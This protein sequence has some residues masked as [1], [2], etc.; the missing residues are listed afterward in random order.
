MHKRI[1]TGLLLSSFFLIVLLFSNPF[2]VA[3]II[4][5]TSFIAYYEWLAVAQKKN[6]EKILFLSILL[7]SMIIMGYFSNHDL[8]IF[9]NFIYLAFWLIISIDICFGSYLTKLFFRISPSL[10][11]LFVIL[12]SWYLLL[13]FNTSD[14]T[15]ILDSQGL[16]FFNN[17]FEGN[18]N[19][20]FIFLFVL[21][22][23]VDTSA[24]TIGKLYG[25]TPLAENISPNKT[26]EGFISS[27]I[28][29]LTIIY[30]S[31]T[32]LFNIPILI[33]DLLFILL[34]SAYCT[35]G[36][37]FISIL[38][39]NNEVKDT[40][41]LLPGHGGVLDRVDS[42]LPVIPIFQFWLFL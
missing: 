37:L 33:N 16:L 12:F 9:I 10:I 41:G 30:F 34:C 38:K 11:G 21:V 23:L 26:L 22:S 20:Y 36:D 17:S 27:L 24:Y 6:L 40:G 31:L 18:L 5:F 8:T 32:Y 13:S 35:I 42:Y 3:L 15:I 39:R 14:T 1:K 4:S 7:F 19:Y 25:S 29:P 2:I 28:I